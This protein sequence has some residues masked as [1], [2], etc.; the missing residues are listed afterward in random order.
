VE[1]EGARVAEGLTVKK[2]MKLLGLSRT[3]YYRQIR[4]MKDYTAQ[5][6]KVISTQH[7]E[8]LGEVALKRL[9]AGHRRV[10]AVR[11][12]VGEDLSGCCWEQPDELLS[13]A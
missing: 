5:P 7:S 9:E 2:A 8:V 11:C 12:G 13:G 4:G 3:S 1:V 10:R 6:R